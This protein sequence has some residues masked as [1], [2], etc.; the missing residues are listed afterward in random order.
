MDNKIQLL[1]LLEHNARASLEELGSML[2]ENID[3]VSS[4]IDDLFQQRVITGFDTL[5]DWEKMGINLVTAFIQVRVIPQQQSGFD[6]IA[7]RIYL[8]P[9]VDSLYLMS[10]DYDF[11]VLVKGNSLNSVAKFVSEKLA[12]LSFIQS[13][14]THFILKNYKDHV[15]EM[16]KGNIDSRL[17]V[18]A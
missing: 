17:K 12:T 6:D 13:T 8:F 5:I 4:N 14:S 7:K 16:S 18:K 15:I 10:G 3:V 9:E 11:T 1:S 2:G